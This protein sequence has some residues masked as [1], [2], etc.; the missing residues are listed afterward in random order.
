MSRCRMQQRCMVPHRQGQVK[1]RQGQV[2]RRQEQVKR[3]QEQVEQDEE[4]ESSSSG[5][6]VTC[7]AFLSRALAAF[8]RAIRFSISFFTNM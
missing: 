3:R 5:C 8:S 4:K 2:K 1:R 7:A 6:V